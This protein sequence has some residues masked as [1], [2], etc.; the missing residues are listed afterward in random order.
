MRFIW[1]IYIKG[2]VMKLI[3]NIRCRVDIEYRRKINS[4]Y[5]KLMVTCGSV[6]R[7]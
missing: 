2:G 1:H 6:R 4:Q 7:G 5:G 3:S